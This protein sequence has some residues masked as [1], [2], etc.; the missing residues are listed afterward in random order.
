MQSAWVLEIKTSTS[1]NSAAIFSASTTGS[2]LQAA[3]DVV[4]G[5]VGS[6]G[7]GDDGCQTGVVGRVGD[8]AA[9]LDSDDQFLCDLGEGGSSHSVLRAL[10]FLNVMPFGMSGHG[11]SS[12]RSSKNNRIY[13]SILTAKNQ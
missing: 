6:L 13:F 5:H 10:G 1:G 7:L 8:T 4:V 11:L 9:F 3:L 12:S 2:L